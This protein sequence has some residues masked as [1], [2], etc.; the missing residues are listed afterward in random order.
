[1]CEGCVGLS[2][3]QTERMHRSSDSPVPSAGRNPGGEDKGVDYSTVKRFYGSLV[4]SVKSLGDYLASY[5]TS[6]GVLSSGYTRNPTDSDYKM[7][8]RGSVSS[9]FFNKNVVSHGYAAT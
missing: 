2:N 5:V 9:G 1:M 4:D 7:S 3:R 6:F 8:E